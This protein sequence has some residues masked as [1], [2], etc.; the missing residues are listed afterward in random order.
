MAHLTF[1]LLVTSTTSFHGSFPSHQ[2]LRRRSEL[3]AAAGAAV[4]AE[5]AAARAPSLKKSHELADDAAFPPPWSR[6][7][8][9]S[10]DA[11]LLYG[12]FYSWQRKMLTDAKQ[13]AM[14]LGTIG[15]DDNTVAS[16]SSNIFSSSGLGG[17]QVDLRP[18]LAL[19]VN[20]E[21]GARVGSTVFETEA[22]RKVR[23]TYFDAGDKVQVFNS[24]WYPRAECGDVPVLGIDLLCFGG[25][26][27]CVACA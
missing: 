7:L 22:F 20:P 17:K 15:T 27:V 1:S 25:N 9:L 3:H 16:S 4:V 12:D 5:A 6:T 10:C 23:M 24:L 8:S 13:P 21:K 19:K 2:L 14:P 26:K 18:D 11:P